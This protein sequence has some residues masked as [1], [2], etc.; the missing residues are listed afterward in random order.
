MA[1]WLILEGAANNVTT[2]HV[3]QGIL[4]RDVRQSDRPS[5]R[6]SLVRLIDAHCVFARLVVP[7][8][9]IISATTMEKSSKYQRPGE[10]STCLLP[11]LVGHEES[12]LSLVADFLGIVRG[13]ELR[14]AREAIEHFEE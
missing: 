11:R 10:G 12:L 13:R 9:C 14:N 5:I 7:A 2:G 3:D 8:T 1:Q 6:G 4:T